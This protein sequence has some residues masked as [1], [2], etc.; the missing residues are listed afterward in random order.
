MICFVYCVKTQNFSHIPDKFDKK[1]VYLQ[2]NETGQ[3]YIKDTMFADL[4]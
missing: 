3:N 2:K 4:K 1:G